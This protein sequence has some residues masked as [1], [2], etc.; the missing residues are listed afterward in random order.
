MT[1]QRSIHAL[2]PGATIAP[3]ATEQAIASV[4]ASL[5]VP[6]PTQLRRFYLQCD[7]FRE[8]RGNAKYLLSLT[9]PDTIG[10][11][12]STTRFYWDEWPA[13]FPQLDFR[14]FVFFG[15]SGSDYVWAI[16]W[17]R[18]DRIIRYHHDLADEYEVAGADIAD[19]W[20]SDYAE[21]D[22]VP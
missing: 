6:L 7:G 10:S 11:L 8:P 15:M 1:P 22:F 21:Y 2:F 18:G 16:D 20:R 13:F 19:A 12:V 14:S 4:E 3:P 9:E 17:A 5:G